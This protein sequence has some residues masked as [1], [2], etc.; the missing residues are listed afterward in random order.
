MSGMILLNEG[1]AKAD[2]GKDVMVN[3]NRLM[4]EMKAKFI[5]E[6]GIDYV[7]MRASPVFA[8]YLDTARTLKSFDSAAL[9]ELE[10]KAFYINLYNCFTMHVLAIQEDNAVSPLKIE[11]MWTKYAYDVGGHTLTLDEIEHGVLRC[12]RGH[13]SAGK[14]AFGAGDARAALALTEFDARVHFALN[15]GAK[16]CPP[17][18]IYQAEKLE[19]QLGMASRNF[20][21]QSVQLD[22][23]G[24]FH[25]S[26]LLLWYMR[27]FGE[28]KV[29]ALK[30]L[31][32]YLSDEKLIEKI[33]SAR[34]DDI[35]FD[36]Y[37]W[38]NNSS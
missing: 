24:K 33:A 31:A 28:N 13:P 18:R 23:E 38:S 15:C 35:L 26:K 36:D 34:E 5:T 32:P 11:G 30:A 8:E 1:Q 25:L 22:S 19:R 21:S 3:L 12:N 9:P 2:A 20:C 4:T 29:E 14:P 16:S 17:V 10:R 7:A 27:D 37:D 6:T